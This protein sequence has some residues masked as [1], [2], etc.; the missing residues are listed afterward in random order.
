MQ[1]AKD[2]TYYHITV[3]CSYNVAAW[4]EVWDFCLFMLKAEHYPVKDL[5]CSQTLIDDSG[6]RHRNVVD[7]I[8]IRKLT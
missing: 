6:S 7:H 5:F 1:V 3:V 8:F 2:T 4:V